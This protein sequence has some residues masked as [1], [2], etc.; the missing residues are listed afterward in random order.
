[1]KVMSREI[2]KFL[3]KRLTSI[4]R[5]L[6]W[7][8]APY[9]WKFSRGDCPL[10]GRSIFVSIKP[11]P[12]MTR[13]LKCMANVTNLSLIPVVKSH[14]GGAYLGRIAYELSIYGSTLHWLEK[15]FNAVISSEFF[16]GCNLGERVNGC[17][18]QDVQNLTFDDN[19][20]DLVTSNQVF[21]HVPDDIKGYKE[22][23]RVLRKG[24][25][26]IF[27]VPLYDIENTRQIA[28]LNGEDIVFIGEPEY[29][30]S[31][32]GGAKSAPA[33]WHHSINDIAKRVASVG[34]SKVKLVD[35]TIA[36]SQREPEK[37]IYAVK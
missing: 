1:M 23:L 30:D 7:A 36:S 27:S 37:V 6:G 10:C 17:L 33:F 21:E 35:V 16:P 26:L 8:D 11:S 9:K 14:C 29:H 25:A 12:F 15:N 18:N 20:I 24:G 13:C 31:R 32:I 19:S 4:I 3:P 28:Y 5:Y 2:S 34:F 22:C